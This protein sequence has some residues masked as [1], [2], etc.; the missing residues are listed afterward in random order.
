M[1]AQSPSRPSRQRQNQHPQPA[2]AL[3]PSQ[4]PE[5]PCLSSPSASRC[6][7]NGSTPKPAYSKKSTSSV[8]AVR[9]NNEQCRPH[10]R[11]TAATPSSTHGQSRGFIELSQCGAMVRLQRRHQESGNCNTRNVGTGGGG[12]EQ[13]I[14][15]A[16]ADAEAADAD[17]E[18]LLAAEL[19]EMEM[20]M[21]GHDVS[22]AMVAMER[23]G[24]RADT[25]MSQ[26]S[27]IF[28][29]VYCT[30]ARICMHV[31]QPT[32]GRLFLSS[33]VFAPKSALPQFDQRLSPH[34]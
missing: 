15:H 27:H 33:I 10:P 22:A 8:S 5:S 13:W 9:S 18:V 12:G 1:N 16:D 32:A 14:N 21:H 19:V 20:Q 3:L 2:D 31:G 34:Y 24:R 17:A 25:S 6:L 28:L 23:E 4:R 7:T 30:S 29:F 11:A 26:R